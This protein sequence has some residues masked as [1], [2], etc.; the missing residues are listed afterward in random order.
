[1]R[2]ICASNTA[3]LQYVIICLRFRYSYLEAYMNT[4]LNENLPTSTEATLQAAKCRKTKDTK[5][6]LSRRKM[7]I[8]RDRKSAFKSQKGSVQADIS[9]Y[10]FKILNRLQSF[11]TF[12]TVLNHFLSNYTSKIFRNVN[13][14]QP[15]TFQ[16][17]NWKRHNKFQNRYIIRRIW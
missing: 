15:L 16:V 13:L 14:N 9:N 3:S 1:M 6:H 5:S 7:Y 4:V 8:S 2:H 10:L 11:L 17:A 12:W